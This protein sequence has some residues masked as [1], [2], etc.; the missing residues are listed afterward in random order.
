MEE[1]AAVRRSA[2]GW[3]EAGANKARRTINIFENK[4]ESNSAWVHLGDEREHPPSRETFGLFKTAVFEN[5]RQLVESATET[6]AHP[7]RG[8]FYKGPVNAAGTQVTDINQ[9]RCMQ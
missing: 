8:L 7:T 4:M 1:S 2:P 9:P 5:P 3:A 6:L